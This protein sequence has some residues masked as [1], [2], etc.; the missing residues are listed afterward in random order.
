[1]SIAH[2]ILF[3]KVCKKMLDFILKMIYNKRN[4]VFSLS[5]RNKQK[6]NRIRVRRPK[7]SEAPMAGDRWVYLETDMLSVFEKNA[8][9][10]WKFF[11]GI[12]RH[13]RGMPFFSGFL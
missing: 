7:G 10:S 6:N 12:F 8:D 1:M 13:G 5:G 9:D 2:S 4:I 11:R 3:V